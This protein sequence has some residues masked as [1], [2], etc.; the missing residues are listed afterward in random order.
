MICLLNDWLIYRG[1]HA[2][3]LNQTYQC[4]SVNWLINQTINYLFDW[5][6]DWGEPNNVGGEDCLALDGQASYRVREHVKKCISIL[7]KTGGGGLHLKQQEEKHIYITSCKF[8][9]S[10]TLEKRLSK[11][12]LFC[13]VLVHQINLK[14]SDTGQSVQLLSAS[15]DG[16]NAIKVWASAIKVWAKAIKIQD[17]NKKIR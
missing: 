10:E 7:S 4:G 13:S 6:I 5:L 2:D 12:S 8:R 9:T 17:Q 3:W 14:H 11:L 15:W 1:P 16:F